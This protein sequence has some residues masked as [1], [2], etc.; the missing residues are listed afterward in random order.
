MSRDHPAS[1]GTACLVNKRMQNEANYR[2]IDLSQPVFDNC[3]RCPADPP[4]RSTVTCDHP[5][6]GWRVESLTLTPH[7]GSHLDAPL[8]KVAGGPAIDDYPID[9]F[10]GQAYILDFRAS[11]PGQ[12]FTSS[13][14]S[15]A[16]R[17]RRELRDKII[18]LATGW[19]E[20]RAQS[21]EWE[22][23]SPFLSPDGA[24]WLVD[25]DIRGVGI[26]HYSIGGLVEPSNTLTHQRLLQA[27]VWIVEDLRFPPQA[28]D[29]RQPVTFWCLPIHLKG[30]SG[31][32][33]RPV[34]MVSE[35]A[36]QSPLVAS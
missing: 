3:P 20:K 29:V 19:G 5:K 8:H 22:R 23:M 32:F 15:R 13:M 17:D 25:Q 35:Q 16:L 18:L 2:L 11:R 24:A 1:K 9:R 12:P 7:T 34:L 4:V 27:N 21:E 10:V 31:A 28:Y 36:V 14:L 26:D 6:D 33:C 30:H